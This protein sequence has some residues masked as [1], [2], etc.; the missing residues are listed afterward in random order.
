MSSVEREVNN[1]V[2][3]QDSWQLRPVA[4]IARIPPHVDSLVHPFARESRPW[5]LSGQTP[6]TSRG[7]FTGN[8]AETSGNLTISVTK[9]KRATETGH[10]H[11]D[12]GSC[13][14]KGVCLACRCGDHLVRGPGIG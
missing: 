4:E 6:V 8:I 9:Q 2:C 10:S 11:D 7:D 1:D 13:E 12:L 3:A 5:R 14:V